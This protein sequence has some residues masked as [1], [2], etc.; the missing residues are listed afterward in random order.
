MDRDANFGLQQ[1]S[2]YFNN[3]K[4]YEVLEIGCGIGIL[5]SVIKEK[6]PHIRVEGIE[7]YKGGFDRLRH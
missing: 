6:Y 5:L 3:N 2:G 4:K 1:L 7:P